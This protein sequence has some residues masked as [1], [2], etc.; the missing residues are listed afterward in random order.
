MVFLDA[1]PL[2][3]DP[4]RVDHRALDTREF[5]WRCLDQLATW[6]TTDAAFDA[7]V[8]DIADLDG[9][10]RD[11]TVLGVY[12]NLRAKQ[13]ARGEDASRFALRVSDTDVRAYLAVIALAALHVLLDNL[14]GG[15][16]GLSPQPCFVLSAGGMENAQLLFHMLRARDPGAKHGTARQIRQMLEW[17]QTA[18]V[19]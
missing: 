8:E 9:V 16:S 14:D 19:Y 12:W 5:P 2:S 1:R 13:A 7:D 10:S 15:A 11:H 6:F 4:L 17:Y 3:S 18:V